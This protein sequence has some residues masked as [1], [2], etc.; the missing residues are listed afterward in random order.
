MTYD[1]RGV[2][3]RWPRPAYGRPETVDIDIGLRQYMLR[4]YNFMAAGLAISGLVAYLA[5]TTGFYQQIAGNSAYL[6]RDAG[7]ARRSAAPELSHR[8]D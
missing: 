5:V 1:P 8:E 2:G 7:A 3:N 6:D 4:V